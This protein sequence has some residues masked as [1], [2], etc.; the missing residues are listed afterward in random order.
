[1]LRKA[2]PF[3]LIFSLAFNVA[4]GAV[5]VYRH[6]ARRRWTPAPPRRP[7]WAA[8]GLTAEQEARIRDSWREAGPKID[9]LRAEAAKHREDLLGLMLAPKPDEQAIL[10]AHGRVEAAEG[11]I[12]QLVIKQ[13]VLTRNLLTDEQR[14]EWL[15][16]M[17]AR[18]ERFGWGRRRGGFRPVEEHGPANGPRPGTR[19]PWKEG[20][21]PKEVRR[22]SAVRDSQGGGP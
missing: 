22:G 18:G 19:E 14:R 17:K 13:M 2:M 8:L 1:M 5:W 7:P 9:A 11:Q 15:R 12:R 3:L 6:G 10:A 16:L 21:R 4:F 20:E